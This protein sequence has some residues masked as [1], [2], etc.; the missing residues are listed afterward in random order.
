MKKIILPLLAASVFI[1]PITS[2]AAAPAGASLQA[3]SNKLFQLQSAQDNNKKQFENAFKEIKKVEAQLPKLHG[4][5]QSQLKVIQD[6]HNKMIKELQ[7]GYE[8]Q[9]KE[10]TTQLN[11]LKARLD[12]K[13]PVQ[14]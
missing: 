9:L 13:G 3:V 6:N 12:K 2:F 11:N 7:H 8:A 10:L 4:Q 1:V 14:G 5:L